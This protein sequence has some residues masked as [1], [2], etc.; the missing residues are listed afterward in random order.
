MQHGKKKYNY[1]KKLKIKKEILNQSFEDM[2]IESYQVFTI[3]VE[4]LIS[5][6]GKN[7]ILNLIKGL[8]NGE[9]LNK[10]FKKIYN[11]SFDELIEDGNRYHKI[12][13]NQGFWIH[14]KKLN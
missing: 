3:L 1:R 5:K 4:Y 8:K 12:A 13:W 6:F 7:R 11:K 10:L 14:F 2:T 9:N